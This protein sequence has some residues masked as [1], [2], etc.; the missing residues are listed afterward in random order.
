[1][2]EF[3]NPKSKL[4]KYT[5][6]CG[7]TNFSPI[8]QTRSN[9]LKVCFLSLSPISPEKTESHKYKDITPAKLIGS[10]ECEA[11]YEIETTRD[12]SNLRLS[13]LTHR[14]NDYNCNFVPCV[15]GNLSQVKDGHYIVKELK[16]STSKH[17]VLQFGEQIVNSD[18]LRNFV[19]I[20]AIDLN[21]VLPT[22]AYTEPV[23]HLAE[24]FFHQYQQCFANL[25]EP[26]FH[27]R[28]SSKCSICSSARSARSHQP[29]TKHFSH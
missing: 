7:G 2:S 26:L 11:A 23:G 14:S 22:F 24:E 25:V 19:G 15:I 18:L 20:G 6:D 21:D 1:M 29:H 9:F 16:H 28:N 4:D 8:L 10:E 5:V 27:K 17:P 13:Q 3:V 12:Y